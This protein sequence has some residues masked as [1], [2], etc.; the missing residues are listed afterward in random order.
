MISKKGF[1]ASRVLMGGA[2]AAAV[3]TALAL[4]SWAGTAIKPDRQ[5]AVRAQIPIHP[6]FAFPIASGDTIAD[7]ELGQPDF[8]RGTANL[9]TPRSLNTAQFVLPNGVAIDQ[10][11]VPNRVYVADFNN[12]RV[13]GW[14]SVAALVNAKPADIVIGQPDFFSNACNAGGVSASTLC[15]PIGIAVDSSGNLYV[16]DNNNNRVL[17]YNTPFIAT[18]T[19]GGGDVIADEVFGQGDNFTS[20]ECLVGPGNLCAPDGVALDSMGNLYVADSGNNRVLE[21]SFPFG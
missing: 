5:L 14:A 7:R 4:G 16:A 3:V 2:V 9:V 1:R 11:S 21:Y 19:P 18:G 6:D 20:K 10:S 15:F 8:F 12:N 13:L 17:E